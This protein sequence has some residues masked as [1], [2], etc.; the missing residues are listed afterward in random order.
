MAEIVIRAHELGKQYSITRSKSAKIG[1]ERLIADLQ[2][3]QPQQRGKIERIW[4]LQDVSCEVRQGQVLAVIGRN[5][6]G[7][8]TLLKIISRITEPTAGYVDIRGRVGSLL[9]VGTGFHPDL[10]G[11]ENVFLN[12]TIL[13]MRRRDIARRFDEIVEFAEIARYI[14]IPV[15]RYSSGMY[16][17]LAF[18][19]AA[20]TD[21]DILLVD[22]V[23]AVGDVSFQRKAL[24]KIAS[25]TTMGCTTLFVSHNSHS[26]RQFCDSAIVLEKGRLVFNGTPDEAVRHY[27]QSPG[28]FTADPDAVF[29]LRERRDRRGDGFLRFTQVELRS[30]QD[31]PQASVAAGQTFKMR[32]CYEAQE[33]LASASVL[34]S[35]TVSNDQ[36][37]VLTN[38]NTRDTQMMTL[39]VRQ[40][41]YFEC[42]WQR[43]NLRPGVYQ[44]NVYG[45]VNGVISDALTSAFRLVVDPGDFFET[46]ERLTGVQGEVFVDH[47]WESCSSEVIA[48]S[49]AAS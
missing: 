4:V 44:C 24:E 3:D 9:E 6:A 49:G 40:S 22:E 39:Q 38:L 30:D 8:S 18:A 7:K 36:G 5:G 15:K 12:G 43:L 13:G 20:H 32:L 23:L 21:A 28:V 34:L 14:D 35:I 26:I 29:S 25:L 46:G 2:Q 45:E 27:M 1:S 47:R 41:G 17:R 19:V 37:V 16:M 33:E 31:H 11:R 10:T 42:V 48:E